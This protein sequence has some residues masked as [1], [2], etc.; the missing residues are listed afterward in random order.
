MLRAVLL[1]ISKHRGLCNPSP[2]SEKSHSPISA[3]L[4]TP[5]RSMGS[6]ACPCFILKPT[7]QGPRPLCHEHDSK[8]NFSS[9]PSSQGSRQELHQGKVRSEVSF[10]P[11]LQLVETLKG[12]LGRQT[13]TEH[14]PGGA[15]KLL[16]Q[17]FV[18]I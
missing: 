8:R 13:H 4:V 10:L 15:A 7:V 18:I 11:P 16:L 12:I 1:L 5:A 14:Q 2:Q 17:H 6:T 3:P 9:S